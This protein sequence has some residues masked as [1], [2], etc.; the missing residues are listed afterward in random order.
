MISRWCRIFK[1]ERDSVRIGVEGLMEWGIGDVEEKEE[2]KEG[3]KGERGIICYICVNM[4]HIIRSIDPVPKNLHRNNPSV[5][6]SLLDDFLRIS[7]TE[8]AE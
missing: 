7:N 8:G 2:R 4:Y 6:I 5:W 1:S 3:K